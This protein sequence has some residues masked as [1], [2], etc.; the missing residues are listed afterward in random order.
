MPNKPFDDV[1]RQ[2][3]ERSPSQPR[4]G[5]MAAQIAQLVKDKGLSTEEAIRQLQKE[6]QAD[7]EKRKPVVEELRRLAAIEN[8]DEATL[9]RIDQ[10]IAEQKVDD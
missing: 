5:A 1:L 3:Q 10:I 2:M 9:K 8:P 7:I 6:L 4:L